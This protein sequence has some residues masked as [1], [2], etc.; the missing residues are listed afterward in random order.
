V[1]EETV[2]PSG[3]WSILAQPSGEGDYIHRALFLLDRQ[4]QRLY[5]LISGA[6]PKPLTPA[7]MKQ[8]GDLHR[9]TVDAVGESA[10]RW[11]DAD[12]VLVDGLLVVPERGGVRLDGDVAP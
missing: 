8:L 1:R 12:V 6:F 9:A 10:V 4:E 11:L 3:R 5:A 7:Q 2:S